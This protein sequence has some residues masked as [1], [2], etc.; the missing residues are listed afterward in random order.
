[1]AYSLPPLINGKS[2]EWADI[3]INILGIPFAGVTNIE[4]S[5]TQEMENVYGAGNRPVSR[6]YGNIT[7]T[8]KVTIL[9]EEVES[10]QAIAPSGTL[11]RIPEFDITV[12]FVDVSLIPRVHTLKNCRFMNNAR[13][14]N[15][16]D[17]SIP[18]ELDLIISHVEFT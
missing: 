12:A 2:Y 18:V 11:Q 13:T 1:M 7:A 9:M 5:E 8:A 17:T 3:I 4:Y 16:G 10:I 6:G 15:Q 14:S